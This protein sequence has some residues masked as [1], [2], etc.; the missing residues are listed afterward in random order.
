MHFLFYLFIHVSSSLAQVSIKYSAVLYSS[1][2]NPSIKPYPTDPLRYEEAWPYKYSELF[3]IGKR[4]HHALGQWFGERYLESLNGCTPV[5]IFARSIDEDAFIKSAQASL[6]GMCLPNVSNNFTNAYFSQQPIFITTIPVKEDEILAMKRVCPKY[7][8]LRQ[9]YLNTEPYK[10]G[11]NSYKELLNY[12]SEH[13][14]WTVENYYDIN[15][16]YNILLIEDL[17]NLALPNWTQAVFPQKL[18]EPACHS[19]ALPSATPSMARLLVGPLIKE[20]V[21]NMSRAITIMP[22]DVILSVYSGSDNTIGNVLTALDLFDGKCPPFIATILMELLYDNYANNFYVRIL[23]QN[24]SDMTEPYAMAIPNCG[25]LCDFT[26]FTEIYGH[27]ISVDWEADCKEDED[28]LTDLQIFLLLLC[29]FLLALGF[30]CAYGL[31]YYSRRNFVSDEDFTGVV[32]MVEMFVHPP[33]MPGSP[34]E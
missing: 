5:T 20:I 25:T 26:T 34:P 14:N 1:G 31:I 3:E 27:L 8:K 11:L 13:T 29:L 32:M 23:Y 4:Q 9:E 30:H 12:L 17:Y 28:F 19:Y 15:E 7:G 2:F 22:S 6:A 21:N 33:I 24:T 18:K 16:I 10:D